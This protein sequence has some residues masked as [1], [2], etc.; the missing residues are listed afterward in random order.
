MVVLQGLAARASVDS[1][2]STAWPSDDHDLPRLL[3]DL[4]RRR[5]LSRLSLRFAPRGEGRRAMFVVRARRGEVARGRASL[6]GISASTPVRS[7]VR[8]SCLRPLGIERLNGCF[9]GAGSSPLAYVRPRSRPSTVDRGGRTT[10]QRRGT[11]PELRRRLSA[12]PGGCARL[13]A[14]VCAPAS[15]LH[16]RRDDP[17]SSATTRAARPSRLRCRVLSNGARV[18]VLQR[19]FGRVA[20]REASTADGSGALGF[21]VVGRKPSSSVVALAGSRATARSRRGRAPPSSGAP[22]CVP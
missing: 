6:G 11:A 14:P 5:E 4:R 12:V 7:C 21:L 15:G 13:P 19:V 20:C 1:A 17:R 18:C 8:P 9:I 16:V 10:T 3:S 22:R 2:S